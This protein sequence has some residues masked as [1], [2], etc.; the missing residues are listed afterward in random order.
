MLAGENTKLPHAFATGIRYVHDL[1]R[2]GY[3]GIRSSRM[4]VSG[5]FR[6]IRANAVRLSLAD[7]IFMSRVAHLRRTRL[8][9]LFSVWESG[10]AS[11]RAHR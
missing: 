6:E 4:H 5:I 8:S 2:A 7:R 3:V 1:G 11:R 9:V 10:R